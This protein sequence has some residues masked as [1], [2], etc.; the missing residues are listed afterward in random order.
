MKCKICNGESVH[1]FNAKVLTKYN[2]DYFQCSN[3]AFVFPEEPY[4]LEESYQNALN[5]EDTGVL[6]RNL[7]F[8]NV[9]TPVLLYMF[10]KQG[11]YLDWGGGYGVFTRLMRDKGLDFYWD[12]KYAVNVLARGF[13][14][15]QTIKIDALT[16]FEVFEHLLNPIETI[17]EML[18]ITDTIIFSTE[19]ISNPP[20]TSGDWWYYSFQ[21]GQHIAFYSRETI[22]FIAGK[23]GLHY[24]SNGYSVHILSRRKHNKLWI[25][26]LM[27]LGKW[28]FSKFLPLQSKTQEDS[29]RLADVRAQQIN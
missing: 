28:G 24:Y 13:E 21:H 25:K 23:Y 26:L 6:Q 12:D 18:G 10:G 14:Y 15:N 19:L 17:E 16:S 1:L 9:L 2:A 20:P 11:K 29:K 5:I 22:A 27:K 8:R 3:C 7:K 4:W